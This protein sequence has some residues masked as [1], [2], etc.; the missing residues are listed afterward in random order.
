[1]ASWN[2]R[3]A[4]VQSQSWVDFTC[5]SEV[6]AS[7]ESGSSMTAVAALAAAFVHTSAGPKTP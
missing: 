4:P 5:A 2:S 7:D 3:S 1:M 6:C